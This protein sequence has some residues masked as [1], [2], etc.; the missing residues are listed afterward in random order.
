MLEPSLILIRW[1]IGKWRSMHQWNGL[2]YAHATFILFYFVIIQ[3]MAR[4]MELAHWG[5]LFIYLEVNKLKTDKTQKTF[6]Y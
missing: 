2:S 1:K 5:F 4:I 6:I 3:L